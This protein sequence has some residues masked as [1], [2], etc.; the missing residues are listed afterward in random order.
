MLDFLGKEGNS[1]ADAR[2]NSC[3]F[4]VYS[5]RMGVFG[6]SLR[7]NVYF[8]TL[9]VPTFRLSFGLYGFTDSSV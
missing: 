2:G 8:R 6:C 9:A 5:I 3:C 1:L 7:Q 4:C